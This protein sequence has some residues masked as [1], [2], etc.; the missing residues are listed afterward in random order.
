MKDE[1]KVRLSTAPRR[2][3]MR[4]MWHLGHAQHIS[5]FAS[6]MNEKGYHTPHITNQKEVH[7][8]VDLMAVAAP[9]PAAAAAA[10]VV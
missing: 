2:M 1:N 7:L 4:R 5:V 9:S 8:N 10:S 3:S 6:Q